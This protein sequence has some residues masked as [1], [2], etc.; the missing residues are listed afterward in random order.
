MFFNSILLLVCSPK[1]KL[2]LR[3]AKTG[4]SPTPIS[5]LADIFV[6]ALNIFKATWLAHKMEDDIAKQSNDDI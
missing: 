5:L 4:K 1:C 2:F 3:P 6:I